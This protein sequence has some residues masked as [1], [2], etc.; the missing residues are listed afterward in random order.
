MTQWYSEWHEPLDAGAP[1]HAHAADERT[2]IDPDTP[3]PVT[4]PE[5]RDS[6]PPVPVTD[7]DGRPILPQDAPR[8]D[9][10]DH[11]VDPAV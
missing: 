7:E 6:L 9:D 10:R 11:D 2:P 1:G 5:P 4:E 3:I 8:R